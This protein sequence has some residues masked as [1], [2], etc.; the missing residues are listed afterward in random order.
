MSYPVLLGAIVITTAN[1]GIRFKEG[2]NTNTALITPDT[3]YLRGDGTASCIL[4]ALKTALEAANASVNTYTITVARS[5]DVATAH[6]LVTI[7]RATGP[8]NFQ[9]LWA[10]SLTTF[11][12]TLLGV[13]A[14]TADNASAKTSTQACAAAW[15]GNDILR[16]LEPFGDRVAEI[17]RRGNGGVIGVSMT[18]HMTSWAVGFA[19]IDEGR[20]LLRRALAVDGDTLEG[21][22]ERFGAGAAFELHEVP[23]SS[24]TTL[25][26]ASS[27]TR[28]AILH[29]SQETLTS[30]RPRRIGPGVPLYDLDTVAHEQ[31][32]S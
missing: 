12:E 15:V 5:I 23:I 6:T 17:A 9:I 20:M 21:F 22:I 18:A 28:V 30:F 19:F 1:Q 11:D 27:S 8:D 4:T 14:N 10:S 29:W 16:E 24:G 31:V 13:T 3:Y 26:A 7:T 25:S 32:T 2:A